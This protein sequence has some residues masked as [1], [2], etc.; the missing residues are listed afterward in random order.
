MQQIFILQ[1]RATYWA[2]LQVRMSVDWKEQDFWVYYD[3][4]SANTVKCNLMD[5]FIG[6]IKE[7]CSDEG[8]S[9]W[10]QQKGCQNNVNDILCQINWLHIADTHIAKWELPERQQF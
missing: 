6:I 8:E 7:Q 2:N 3:L 5:I 9:K 10:K 1:M 4:Q